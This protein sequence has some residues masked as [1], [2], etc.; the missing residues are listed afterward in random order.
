MF[1]SETIEFFIY[2][3]STQTHQN[4]DVFHLSALILFHLNIQ[5]KPSKFQNMH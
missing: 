3:I 1:V 4:S 2:D 5:L